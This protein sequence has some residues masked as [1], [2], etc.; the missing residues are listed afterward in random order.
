MHLRFSI[1]AILLFTACAATFLAAISPDWFAGGIIACL[2]PGLL[3][4]VSPL[5]VRDPAERVAYARGAG[6][7]ALAYLLVSV[8]M[9]LAVPA[10]HTMLA[11][12]ISDYDVW[13]PMHFQ[14]HA[15]RRDNVFLM[16]F[17]LLSGVLGGRVAIALQ[18][19]TEPTSN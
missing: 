11:H 5:L 2:I 13:D 12:W 10:P 3:L 8:L 14:I 9:Q 16:N 17:I 15:F 7:G 18:R 4:P 19:P 6:V 1:L